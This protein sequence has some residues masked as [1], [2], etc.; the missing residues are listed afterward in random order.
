MGANSSKLS[1]DNELKIHRQLKAEHVELVANNI[2]EENIYKRLHQVGTELENLYTIEKYTVPKKRFGRTELQMPIITCGGMRQQQ[3]WTQG[4]ELTLETINKEC[5]TN[6]EKILD[7]AMDLGINHFETARGYGSSETQYGPLLKKFPRESYILQSKVPAKEDANEFRVLLEKTFQEL[8]IDKEGYLDLF[9]FHGI[10]K[11]EILDWVIRPGGCMEVVK[12]YQNNGKI[13]WIGFS[14][15]AMTPLIV[16]AIETN[17]FDY[18]NLHYQFIGSYTASGTGNFGGNFEAIQA[19]N[20]LDMGVFIISG[21]DKGGCLYE[22]SKYLFRVSF[23]FYSIESTSVD[24]TYSV[25]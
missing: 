1:S 25:F 4:P 2:S 12:E 16:K 14:T 8:Q 19:A 5:Q 9:A 22:P 17:Q 3:T 15:H 20:K 24:F 18:V 7:R 21:A 13:K 10:N 23:C 6:F 11:P